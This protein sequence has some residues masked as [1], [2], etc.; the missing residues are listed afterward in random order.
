MHGHFQIGVRL[1]CLRQPFKR[2]LQ[3]AAALG[4]DAVEINA[5]DHVRPSTLS[6]TGLRQLRKLL[7]DLGL[8]VCSIA[9]PTRRGY[10][11]AEELERR[12]QATKA[13]MDMA[14]SLGANVVVNHVGHVAEPVAPSESNDG[15]AVPDPSQ[16]ILREALTDIGRHG[17][18]C[19]AFLAARTG[20]EE[21]D[22]MGRLIESLPAHFLRV[23]F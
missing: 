5:R 19:G 4:A 22:W 1:D 10:H 13:A 21:A 16:A 20:G 9:F 12:I 3:T 14:Y 18:H 6:A 8:K 2:A 15:D 7:D 17:Q 23:D 11:V